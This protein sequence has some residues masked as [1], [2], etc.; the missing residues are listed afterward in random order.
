M[1]NVS[2]SSPENDI[3]VSN[4]NLVSNASDDASKVVRKLSVNIIADEAS[5]SSPNP[6]AHTDDGVVTTI[7][8]P[9]SETSHLHYDFDVG[10]VLP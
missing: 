1:L 4:V 8:N 6:S 2:E 5:A 7:R 10:L 9:G 3:E